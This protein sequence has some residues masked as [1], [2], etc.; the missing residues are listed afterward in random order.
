MSED[1][2]CS[3]NCNSYI[4]FEHPKPK[5]WSRAEFLSFF[6]FYDLYTFG[7]EILIVSIAT[8][9]RKKRTT[10]TKVRIFT[11]WTGILCNTLW[12]WCFTG[13]ETLLWACGLEQHTLVLCWDSLCSLNP[14]RRLGERRG[15]GEVPGHGWSQELWRSPYDCV[16]LGWA[17]ATEQRRAEHHKFRSISERGSLIQEHCGSTCME[18]VSLGQPGPLFQPNCPYLYWINNFNGSHFSMVW[19][20]C[21]Y[22]SLR[23][24]L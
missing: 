17:P 5:N 6:S 22:N 21:I 20:F 15:R 3:Q 12:L 13:R 4:A 19:K 7:V 2:S 1:Y 24:S 10:K 23:I 11:G 14:R 18:W 9:K 8:R 16:L